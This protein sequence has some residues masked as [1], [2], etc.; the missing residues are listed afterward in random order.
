MNPAKQTLPAVQVLPSHIL[1]QLTQADTRVLEQLTHLW[2]WKTTHKPGTAIWANPSLAYL[3]EKTGWSTRSV[4][5]SIRH[6]KDLGILVTRQ[7]KSMLVLWRTNLYTIG[8]VMADAILGVDG[9]KKPKGRYTDPTISQFK[10]DG[11]ERQKSLFP[12]CTPI[13]ASNLLPETYKEHKN[14][15]LADM[16]LRVAQKLRLCTSQQVETRQILNE[17]GM[18]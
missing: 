6:L 15:E 7:L 16:I 13:L 3:A 9:W 17:E 1:I 14:K 5:R 4:S 2:A 12:N 11:H 18:M 8:R 10:F